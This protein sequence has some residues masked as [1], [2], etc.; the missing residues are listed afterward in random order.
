MQYINDNLIVEGY[1]IQH[2]DKKVLDESSDVDSSTP[3]ANET[4]KVMTLDDY[5]NL[6][7]VNSNV[8]YFII[9]NPSSPEPEEIDEESPSE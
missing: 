5:N 2:G 8:I 9:E 1:I 6:E 4:V 3:S 7:S